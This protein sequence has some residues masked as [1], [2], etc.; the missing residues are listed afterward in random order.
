MW[1]S[2]I[3]GQCFLREKKQGDCPSLLPEERSWFVAQGGKIQGK[4]RD[5]PQ[6]RR[7]NWEW[8]DQSYYT[9]QERLLVRE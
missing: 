4:S 9:S 8:R 2:G 3:I 1:L 5:L 7:S 6:L